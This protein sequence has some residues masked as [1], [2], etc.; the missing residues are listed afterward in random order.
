MQQLNEGLSELQSR[1]QTLCKSCLHEWSHFCTLTAG[2]RNVC[3]LWVQAYMKFSILSHCQ[4][5]G[6]I[7][8]AISSVLNGSFYW[9][10][11]WRTHIPG[12]KE[13]GLRLR[14]YCIL[15]IVRCLL[16]GAPKRALSMFPQPFHPFLQWSYYTIVSNLLWFIP[17]I[18]FS[19]T[20]CLIS[21]T[22]IS[23]KIK[24]ILALM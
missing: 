10:L 18:D 23:N 22:L 15:W 16:V 9:F 7:E 6:V 24:T 13:T 8:V 21:G 17:N 19:G 4:R 1:C 12:R 2:R 5:N 14:V 3:T 20:S 11:Q